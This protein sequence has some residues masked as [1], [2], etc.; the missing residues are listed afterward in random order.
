[1]CV[2]VCVCVHL[3]ILELHLVSQLENC[4]YWSFSNIMVCPHTRATM[5]R[6]FLMK[7]F[8]AYGLAMID[9]SHGPNT[10]LILSP[11]TSACGD[12]WHYICRMSVDDSPI[13]MQG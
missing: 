6:H 3:D 7:C 5:C 13:F 4:S 12:M 10:F 1:M 2:C 8:M 11:W 9:Q